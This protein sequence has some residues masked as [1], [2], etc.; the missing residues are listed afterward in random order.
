MHHWTLTLQSPPPPPPTPPPPGPSTPPPSYLQTV[1]RNSHFM[2]HCTDHY[3][4]KHWL[5]TTSSDS[6]IKDRSLSSLALYHFNRL[7]S[8]FCTTLSIS[9]Q[10]CVYLTGLHSICHVPHATLSIFFFTMSSFVYL[11]SLYL[12]GGYWNCICIFMSTVSV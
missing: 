9:A 4:I 11:Y 7:I 1:T 10:F 12:H 8:S 5:Q 6:L 2:Q 3:L